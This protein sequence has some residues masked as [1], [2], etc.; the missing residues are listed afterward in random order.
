MRVLGGLAEPVVVT[1]RGRPVAVLMGVEAHERLENDRQLLRMLA[2][3][4]LESVAGTGV[5]L[6]EVLDEADDLLTEN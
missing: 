2:I 5:S 4:E 1:R 3:G 6:D